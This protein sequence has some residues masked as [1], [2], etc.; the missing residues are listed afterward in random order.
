MLIYLP[1]YGPREFINNCKTISTFLFLPI[2]IVN[3][4]FV[5]A[6]GAT[7]RCAILSVN[8]KG[9]FHNQYILRNQNTIFRMG[10]HKVFCTIFVAVKYFVISRKLR[11]KSLV[12]FIVGTVQIPGFKFAVYHGVTFE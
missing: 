12:C 4:A 2:Q 3:N 11:S 9:H 10:F 8:G 1:L 6:V 5:F 7:Y